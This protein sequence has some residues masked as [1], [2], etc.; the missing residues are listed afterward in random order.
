MR[1]FGIWVYNK[2]TY[3]QDNINNNYNHMNTIINDNHIINI[4]YMDI[5]NINYDNDSYNINNDNDS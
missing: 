2:R 4:G 3:R 1:Y 5:G